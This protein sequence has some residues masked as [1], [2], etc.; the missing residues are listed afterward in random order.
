MPIEVRN[1]THIYMPG[2]PFETKALDD[3]SFTVRE[4]DFIGLIGHTGSGKSTLIMHLNGLMRPE[5]GHVLVDGLDLGEKGLDLRQVRK[6]VCLVFQYPEYQLFEET[7][8]SDVMFGPRNQG[9]SEEACRE[10]ASSSLR[11]VGLTDET[12]WSKSPFELSGGQKR[13]VAIAG[14]L[15]MRPSTL[16]LD[17]PTAGLDPRGRDE[18]MDI[19]KRIHAEGT[20][21]IMVS[22][23]MTDVS[24]L[25]NRILV[26]NHARLVA[27]AKPEEIFLYS[28]TV[29]KCG[30]ELPPCAQL[31][32][33]LK[34]RGIDGIPATAFTRERLADALAS[35]LR[36]GA[37]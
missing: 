21:V 20:T 16:I 26:M 36:R 5:P 2:T 33:R 35:R 7:I 9:L 4:G 27:D 24:R 18:I 28:V 22:H 30:L 23:S 13:R 32:L 8:L 29:R 11:E 1:L 34:E 19:M 15:A 10:Q 37:K 25:C 3:V 31:I 12:L 14:V 6:S 17:E